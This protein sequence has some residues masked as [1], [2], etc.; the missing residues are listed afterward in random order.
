MNSYNILVCE[1][2]FTIGNSIKI[3]L[4]NNGYNVFYAENGL[5]GIEI[6][7]EHEIHLVIMDL[8]MPE[9]SGEEAIG[10]LRK[11]SYVP[12]I[13]LSA[14][15]EEDDKVN[16]LNI[17]ADDYITKPFNSK[18]LV[19]RVNSSIRRFYRY[20]ED[21][22]LDDKIKVE[23]TSLDLNK[24]II[25]INEKEVPLTSLEFDI[26]KLLMSN[27]GRIFSMDEIYERVWNEP[28]IE[29]KTVS[30]HI[31]RIRE[32]IEIDPKRPRY[33]K[34]AWGVGYKFEAN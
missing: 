17:G 1:D 14:K 6:F 10:E 31:R 24:K 22:N 15:S 25:E 34:V 12:I 18:E 7:N 29:S 19:A 32:K 4:E 21:E 26:L 2:D 20:M 16:G 11:K 8:M 9:M 23:E 13:I 27:P 5:K 30:V 33:L 28:A 3:F